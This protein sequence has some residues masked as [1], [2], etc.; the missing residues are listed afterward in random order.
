MRPAADIKVSHSRGSLSD[1]TGPWQDRAVKRMLAVIVL[2]VVVWLGIDLVGPRRVDIRR[3]D[4]DVV[5]RL[6]TEMWRS[7]YDRKPADLY[8]Q[9]AELLRAQ[10]HFPVARSHAVAA[11][12]AKA[13]FVFKDGHN[14]AEYRRALPDLVRYYEAIRKVSATSFD[15]AKTAELELEWWIVHR[16]RAT[17]PPGALEHALAVAAAEL[18]RVPPETMT[19]YARERTD[20]MEIRDTKARAGGVTEEDWGRIEQHLRTSWRSLRDAVQ[21]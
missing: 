5:A 3:F 14:R 4:P 12:A 7:Y 21:P 1:A 19:V 9:L 18:Y 2:G 8:F 20:A 17:Q 6:D 13:A 11:S 16:Q 10:F 15:V